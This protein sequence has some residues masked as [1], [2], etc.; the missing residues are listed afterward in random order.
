M[1]NFNNFNFP[2]VEDGIKKY[3]EDKT[4]NV[5]TATFSDLVDKYDELEDAIRMAHGDD[6]K[7]GGGFNYSLDESLKKYVQENHIYTA[8]D[9]LRDY[10]S[11][12][13][14]D[15]CKIP[16]QSGIKLGNFPVVTPDLL[17]FVLV[18]NANLQDHKDL[19]E[20]FF[21]AVKRLIWKNPLIIRKVGVEGIHDVIKKKYLPL[22]KIYL[23]YYPALAQAWV[24]DSFTKVDE[25]EKIDI[26]GFNPFHIALIYKT[27][28]PADNEYGEIYKYLEGMVTVKKMKKLKD[29]YI[30]RSVVGPILKKKVSEDITLTLQ[31]F[32]QNGWDPSPSPT[33]KVEKTEVDELND[34]TSLLQQLLIETKKQNEMVKEEKKKRERLE[35]ELKELKEVKKEVSEQ[36]NVSI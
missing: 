30:E 27:A 6:F 34:V 36:E 26:I 12:I 8:K 19:R 31:S 24:E 18:N 16:L 35:K 11:F 17:F 15:T 7:E 25:K 21:D 22:L 14:L 5:P 23:E 13:T 28:Y 9:D 3:L 33:V 4:L 20:S 29:T 2:V 32:I 10:Y 1:Q